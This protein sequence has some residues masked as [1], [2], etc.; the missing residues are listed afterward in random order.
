V[1]SAQA[2]APSCSRA[3]QQRGTE[4]R[5]RLRARSERQRP[6]ARGS[7]LAVR[8]LSVMTRRM[9]MRID[10]AAT[11]SPR[12]ANT[13]RRSASAVQHQRQ[14]AASPERDFGARSE[15][16][17]NIGARGH[18]RNTV[19]RLAALAP[20][21]TLAVD[22]RSA[23]ITD[24]IT[25]GP[26]RYRRCRLVAP[27]RARADRGAAAAADRGQDQSSTCADRLSPRPRL[28]SG[29]RGWPRLARDNLAQALS[30][31]SNRTSS[32]LT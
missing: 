18:P 13:T 1:N 20:Q 4:R 8:A 12:R 22:L 2:C 11:N 5:E 24:V 32:H 31:K 16:V 14:P 26:V 6:D 17:P 3:K 21:S 27:R 10:R 19:F 7:C 23:W 9:P 29:C 30:L 15:S 28:L 25:S